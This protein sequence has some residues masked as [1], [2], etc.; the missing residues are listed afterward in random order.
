MRK[1]KHKEGK[2]LPITQLVTSKAG[3]LTQAVSLFITGL[4]CLAQFQI[5]VGA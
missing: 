1:L 3:M 5:T 4:S 2:N